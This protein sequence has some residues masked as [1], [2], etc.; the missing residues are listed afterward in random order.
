MQAKKAVP[1]SPFVLRGLE[2]E[3][4]SEMEIMSDSSLLFMS[5]FLMTTE[6]F[7]GFCVYGMCAMSMEHAA[8]S[9]GR[10]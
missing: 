8:L 2:N 3:S 7:L 10:F 9:L 5:E 1:I 4:K 6:L